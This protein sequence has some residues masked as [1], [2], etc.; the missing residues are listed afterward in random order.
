MRDDFD[1]TGGRNLTAM[2]LWSWSRVFGA[3]AAQVVAPAAMPTVDALAG[4]CIE[5]IY[6]VLRRQY[7]G[8]SLAQTFLT[9]KDIT[10]VEP[11]RSLMRENIPG[12]LPPALPVFVAQG[13]AD[14]LVLPGVTAA[15]VRKLCAAGSAVKTVMVPGAGHGF[16]ARDAATAAVEWMSDRFARG[17]PPDDCAAAV[18]AAL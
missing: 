4:E 16:V 12:A 1:S 8:R 13:D 18:A 17:V 10:R 14:T 11:W 2:T 7:T 6:D 5:S 3:P 15:Y 9:V